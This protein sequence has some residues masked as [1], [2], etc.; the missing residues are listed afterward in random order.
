MRRYILTLAGC[1]IVLGGAFALIDRARGTSTPPP[2]QLRVSEETATPTRHRHADGHP[3]GHAAARRDEPRARAG[4]PAPVLDPC[5][6]GGRAQPRRGRPD[7][8]AAPA[9]DRDAEA[10]PHGD[11]AAPSHGH[12][13]TDSGASGPAPTA[14]APAPPTDDDDDDDGP[15]IDD[16]DGDDD[17]D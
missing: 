16:D 8:G 2:I 1:L 6:D 5:T 11:P 3:R 14:A 17:D 12:A 15:E 13:G 10:P 4:T 7:S 9:A